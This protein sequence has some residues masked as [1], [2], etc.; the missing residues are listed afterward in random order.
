MLMVMQPNYPA[1]APPPIDPS[2]I[3]QN[4]PYS[5]IT[6]PETPKKKG[7]NLPVPTGKIG[8][9]IIVAGMFIIILMLFSIGSSLLSKGDKVKIQQLKDV[10]YQQGEL[11]RVSEIGVKKAKTTEG[12]NLAITTQ[13]SL[14][15]EQAELQKTLKSLKI[16]TDT[17]TLGGPN[18]KTD[19]LLT[20]AEQANQFDEVFIKTI[21]ANLLTYAKAVQTAYKNTPDTSK[22]TKS[23]L[24]AQFKDAVTLSGFKEN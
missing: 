12:K 9:I 17:K 11:I 24:E 21:Q 14:I 22:V 5:F 4:N 16:K 23:A 19:E 10:V 20:N 6:N 18:K 1:P 15:S 3:S 2:Q 7:S 8:R 13:L